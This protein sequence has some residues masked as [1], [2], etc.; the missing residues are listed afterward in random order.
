MDSHQIWYRRTCLL[1]GELQLHFLSSDITSTCYVAW[2]L[3]KKA[4]KL[5]TLPSAS[6]VLC[7]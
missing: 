6:A 1:H 3:T 5:L 7:V 4:A 2:L